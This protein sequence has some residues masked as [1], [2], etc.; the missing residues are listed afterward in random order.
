M[1][2]ASSWL[3]FAVLTGCASSKPVGESNTP[4]A[5]AVTPSSKSIG[6]P[7]ATIEE[8]AGPPCPPGEPRG[9]GFPPWE[10]RTTFDRCVRGPNERWSV[11]RDETDPEGWGHVLTFEALDGTTWTLDVIAPRA[12]AR[13]IDG[14][15]VMLEGK[16]RATLVSPAGERVWSASHPE[17]GFVEALAVGWDH[18]I[19]FACGYSVVRLDPDGQM[20]W[21]VWPFGDHSVRNVW[22]DRDGTTYVTGNG[23]VAALDIDGKTRWSVSTG[24]NRAIGRV[25]WNAAGNL[26]FDTSMDALHSPESSSGYRFYYDDEPRQLFEVT[27]S[28]EIV[29]S[30]PYEQ[31]PPSQGWPTVLAVPEDGSHRVP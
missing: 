8:F 30:Q 7:A 31:A 20:A 28:G 25:V 23:R 22:I 14:H 3:V 17:C 12:L 27:R 19:V 5:T 18:A 21:H 1:T 15:L 6:E 9:E 10:T 13:R 26:V 11:V 24:F 16:Q 4:N 2:R 29:R